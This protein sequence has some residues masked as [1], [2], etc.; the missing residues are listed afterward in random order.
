[1]ALQGIQFEVIGYLEL[2]FDDEGALRG[3]MHTRD[4]ECTVGP[5][6]LC[7]DCG[8]VH[9]TA[10]PGCGGRGFHDGGCQFGSGE[11]WR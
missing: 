2:T 7:V 1:M 8:A 3:P 10:C 11:V 9:R 4:N 6:G 5:G